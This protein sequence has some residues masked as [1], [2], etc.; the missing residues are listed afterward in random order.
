MTL[1]RSAA[2]LLSLVPLLPAQP[3]RFGTPACSGP[4]REFADRV[5]FI[6]CHDSSRKVALWVGYQLTPDQLHRTADRPSQ[7]RTDLNLAGPHSTNADYRNSGL[8]RGHLAPAA[9]FAWSPEAIRATFLLSNAIPQ[10]QR[11]NA[12]TWAQL[13]AAVRDLASRSDSVY[14]FTGV[15]FDS[16]QPRLIGPGRVAVPSQTFKVI[17]AVQGSRKTMYAAIVPNAADGTA[18]LS[19]LTTTVAEVELRTGLDFCA[20]LEE[21]EERRLE[22]I[23][24]A[25]PPPT[26]KRQRA[27]R[28]E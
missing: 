22:S 17:L 12:G 15:L 10:Y 23:R 4:G 5:Y 9:D 20:A 13:E 8:S 7:F 14:V 28:D 21:E 19:Q 1:V 3:S 11:V 6:L 24:V 2:L 16:A 26:G 27:H 25:F 18:P